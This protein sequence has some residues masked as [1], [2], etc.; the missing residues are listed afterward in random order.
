METVRFICAK[1]AL[2]YVSALFE[3]F[4]INIFIQQ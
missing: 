2:F 4:E 1:T 3:E